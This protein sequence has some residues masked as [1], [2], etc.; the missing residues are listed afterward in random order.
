MRFSASHILR[1]S[2]LVCIYVGSQSPAQ[3][4]AKGIRQSTRSSTPENWEYKMDG[5]LDEQ[6]L[7]CRGPARVTIS[8]SSSCLSWNLAK[9]QCKGSQSVD[10]LHENGSTGEICGRPDGWALNKRLPGRGSCVPHVVSRD[11][12]V[13]SFSLDCTWECRSARNPCSGQATYEFSRIS[14]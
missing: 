13:V 1:Y 6:N 3:A 9:Q 4:P 10:W 5:N 14:N 7:S 2:L 8:E 11:G 12:R